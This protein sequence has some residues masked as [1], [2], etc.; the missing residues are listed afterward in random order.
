VIAATVIAIAAWG[1]LLWLVIAPHWSGC[2]GDVFPGTS[3]Q[4]RRR[5][6][7]S[8]WHSA[9]DVVWFS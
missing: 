7:A 9:R 5:P 2:C 3:T 1:A 6:H 4:C 8:R